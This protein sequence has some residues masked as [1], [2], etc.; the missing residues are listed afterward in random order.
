[1][2]ISKQITLYTFILVL[3][4]LMAGIVG[5]KSLDRNQINISKTMDVMV[6]NNGI[7]DQFNTQLLSINTWFIN[8]NVQTDIRL[9]I[10]K[11]NSIAKHIELPEIQ[12]SIQDFDDITSLYLNFLEV[13]GKVS[14]TKSYEQLNSHYNFA[15]SRVKKTNEL[16]RNLAA[17]KANEISEGIGYSKFLSNCLTFLYSILILFVGF[18]LGKKIKKTNSVQKN[19]NEKLADKQSFIEAADKESTVQVIEKQNEDLAELNKTLKLKNDTLDNFI[20]RVSHDLKAPLT[21]IKSF[22]NLLKGKLKGHHD[23]HVEK[24]IGYLEKNSEKLFLTIHDLMEVSRIEQSLA[25][26]SSW[27][28]INQ[29]IDQVKK[30]LFK[31]IVDSSTKIKISLEKADQVYFSESNLKS[32]ISNLITNSIKYRNEEKANLIQISTQVVNNVTQL[33]I[34]DNGIGI[35]LDK[36]RSKLFTIFNRFHTHK[37]GNGVGLYIVKKLIVEAGGDIEIDS[38]V[39]VGTTFTLSFPKRKELVI[40]VNTN[41]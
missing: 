7:L 16:N 37:E 29:T 31:E 15:S 39:N 30:D 19:Y 14:D 40:P 35:D 38:T 28:N 26:K 3:V 10:L 8:P 21:N 25:Q 34:K 32:I 12:N 4:T 18:V 22:T 27:I 11:L 13:E 24:T 33:I 36:H 1:M 2:L 5:Y 41:T 9:E 17:M 6:T 20:Y 23:P